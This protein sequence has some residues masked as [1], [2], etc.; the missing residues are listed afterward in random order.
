[1]V[2][3]YN[4]KGSFSHIQLSKLGRFTAWLVFV[5][6]TRGFINRE[7]IQVEEERETLDMPF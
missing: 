3:N 6:W 4:I 1:M 7:I 2:L 5:F